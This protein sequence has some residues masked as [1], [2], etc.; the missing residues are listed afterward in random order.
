MKE[1]LMQ[2]WQKTISA[3]GGMSK[4]VRG[5][6]IATLVLVAVGAVAAIW[7]MDSKPYSVLFTG[8][9]SEDMSSVLT[10][11]EENG[12]TDYQV[13]D[14]NTIL[15]PE[16]Q[17]ALLKAK[18]L[19]QGYPSSGF[20]YSMYLDNVNALSTESDRKTLYLM[21]LQERLGAVVR[22]FDGVGDAAV[23]IA[24]G[25]DR[26]YVLD[27][28]NVLEASASVL[29]TMKNAKSLTN[30]QAAAIRGLIARAVQGLE[31][32]N[33]TIS[34]TAGKTYAGGGEDAVSSDASQ[35]KLALEEQVNNKV[36][37]NIMQVLTP[38][39]GLKNISVSVNS[40]VDVSR[41]RQEA[42]EYTEPTWAG[43]GSTGGKG[44]IGS[45]VYDY[46]IS[47]DGNTTAGGV[48]GTETNSDLTTY[49]EE[50]IKPDGT[51]SQIQASGQQDFLV[52]NTKT[53]TERSAGTVADL[54]VSVS[55]N[56]E[57]TGMVGTD[58]LLR[59]VARAAGIGAGMEA[60]KISI[61]A[62]PFYSEDASAGPTVNVTGIPDWAIY[63]LIAGLSLFVLLLVIFLL[64]RRRRKKK[65]MAKQ[66]VAYAFESAAAPRV[67]P[68]GA[69]IMDLRTERSMELRKDVRSF[70]ENNPEI[71][72]QLVRSWLRGGED[73][74]G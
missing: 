57:A 18:L 6:L 50:G 2:V 9:S 55:I 44:I 53:Q 21:D 54:M 58:S 16:E 68:M 12:T 52:D 27:S 35:L 20:G 17:E 13:K 25:E 31:I 48:V 26:R 5:L 66:P 64:I 62:V 10:Y 60:E 1:K 56:S 28:G 29:V 71:A 39:F 45:R 37:N 19:M 38:M 51:E 65:K 74:N 47:R 59:H 15:V 70:A 8:L 23:T 69:D 63:A 72:A 3:F 30:E 41:S 22:C 73:G 4:K 46:S 42:T 61:L 36:R 33:I 43:D 49:V 32:S 14:N 7:I 67:E 24:S 34:D 40:T 11:L